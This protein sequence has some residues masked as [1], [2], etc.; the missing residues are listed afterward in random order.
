MLMEVDAKCETFC[1]DKISKTPAQNIEKTASKTRARVL[2]DNSLYVGNMSFD[3]TSRSLTNTN[4][5]SYDVLAS[6]KS[7]SAKFHRVY[8]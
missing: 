2:L 1:S 5:I 4:R 7:R 8:R 6:L 3:T